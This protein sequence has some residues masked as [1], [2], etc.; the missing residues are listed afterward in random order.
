[1]TYK[2]VPSEDVS[3]EL[4]NAHADGIVNPAARWNVAHTYAVITFPQGYTSEG[5]LSEDEW[6]AYLTEHEDEWNV[7]F[8]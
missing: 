3:A 8:P 6:D 1:M 7:V 2:I 4:E 5:I